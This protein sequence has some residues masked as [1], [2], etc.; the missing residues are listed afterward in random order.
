MINKCRLHDRNCQQIIISTQS[1]VF[2][3]DN[4]NYWTLSRTFISKIAE[5]QWINLGNVKPLGCWAGTPWT[6]RQSITGPHRGKQPCTLTPRY[7]FRMTNE[8]NM[9]V[10]FNSGR[11]PEFLE[12]THAC[13]GRTCKL[14]TER[15]QPGFKPA[16]FMLWGD[17]ANHHTTLQPSNC[18]FSLIFEWKKICQNCVL[19]MF[20]RWLDSKGFL[21]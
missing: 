6:G 7:N 13:M 9:H 17:G 3:C 16:T 8:P 2:N 5:N 14:H 18:S 1:K 12:R 15:P 20:F 19:N 10:F 4:V 21:R 11:K